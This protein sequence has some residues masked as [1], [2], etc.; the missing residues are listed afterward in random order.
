M[1]AEA[2]FVV[3]A[4]HADPDMQ[5]FEE[6][7]RRD[8][9][10][11]GRVIVKTIRASGQRRESFVSTI[12]DGN[13]K[14]H[15]ILGDRVEVIVPEL[16]LLRDVKTRWDSTFHMI[17]RLRTMRPVSVWSSFFCL[18]IDC[19]CRPLIISLLCL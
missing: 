16:Q 7:V 10:A 6:A 5:T 1:E 17:S 18:F 11:L 15:F 13:A 12:R 14:K 9:I 3:V 2:Q 8:P 19:R 4:P